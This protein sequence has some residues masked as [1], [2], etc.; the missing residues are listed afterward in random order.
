MSPF[1]GDDETLD[2]EIA[3]LEGMAKRRLKRYTDDLRNLDRDLADLRKERARRRAGSA[4]AEAESVGEPAD[5]V[6]EAD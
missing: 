4:I 5:P 3:T 6:S 1:R 2:R